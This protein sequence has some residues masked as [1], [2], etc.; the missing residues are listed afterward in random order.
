M[1]IARPAFALGGDF[2]GLGQ[3]GIARQ[4]RDALAEDLMVGQ[5]AAPVIV[6]VHRGK[7]VVDQR[8]GVDALDGTGQGIRVGFVAPT[9]RGRRQAQ[10]GADAFAAGKQGVAHRAMDGG[11]FDRRRR[12]EPIQCEPRLFV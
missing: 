2:K 9:S 8:V 5:F 1:R 7:V 6:I 4:H 12:Q 11:G 10:G 3:Q